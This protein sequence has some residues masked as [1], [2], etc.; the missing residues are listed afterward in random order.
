MAIAIAAFADGNSDDEG[1]EGRIKKR[2]GM[3]AGKKKKKK[4]PGFG[5]PFKSSAN[6]CAFLSKKQTGN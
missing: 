4:P 3:R 6:H 5:L 1:S 2:V